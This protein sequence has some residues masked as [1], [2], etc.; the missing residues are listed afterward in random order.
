V[1]AVVTFY[2]AV[3]SL[4]TDLV[5]TVILWLIFVGLVLLLIGAGAKMG[6]VTKP[7]AGSSWSSRCW[8]GTTLREM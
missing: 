1:F 4:R 8:P 3:A 7:A 2:L 6:D 5:L